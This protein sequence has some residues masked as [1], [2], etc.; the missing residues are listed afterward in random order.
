MGNPKRVGTFEERQ[1]IKG[2]KSKIGD[3]YVCGCGCEY[4]I[5]ATNGDCICASCLRAQS[6]IIVNE[7]APVTRTLGKSDGT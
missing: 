3:H 5:L 1:E 6:R 2:Q 7:L 4:W